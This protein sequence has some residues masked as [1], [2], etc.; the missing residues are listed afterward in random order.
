MDAAENCNATLTNH[1]VLLSTLSTVISRYYSASS[2]ATATNRTSGCELAGITFMPVCLALRM[3]FNIPQLT[4][5]VEALTT[6]YFACPRRTKLVLSFFRPLRHPNLGIFA[7]IILYQVLYYNFFSPTR[8]THTVSGI[9]SII[10]AEIDA[11]KLTQDL[12]FAI[13]QH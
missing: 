3:Y 4:A 12:H 2:T 7:H 5:H 10:R 1:I 8:Y 6:T 13:P 11:T 9:T